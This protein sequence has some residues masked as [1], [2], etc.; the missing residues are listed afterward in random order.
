M[1]T[2]RKPTVPRVL[3]SLRDP[4]VPRA[5]PSLWKSPSLRA[6]TAWLMPTSPQQSPA[7]QTVAASSK[8]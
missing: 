8:V 3:P 2:L 5:L 7:P 6:L 1:P 4:P